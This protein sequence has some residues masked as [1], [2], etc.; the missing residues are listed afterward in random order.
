MKA[1][2]YLIAQLIYRDVIPGKKQ[3]KAVPV[4]DRDGNRFYEIKW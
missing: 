3:I 1:L 2:K 4:T